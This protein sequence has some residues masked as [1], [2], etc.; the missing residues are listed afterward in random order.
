MKRISIGIALALLLAACHQHGK[1]QASLK[2]D[3]PAKKGSYAIG[4]S[5][6][7]TLKGSG[8]EVDMDAF[9]AGARTAYAG[10]KP[11]LDAKEADAARQ[12]FM[13]RQMQASEAKNKTLADANEKKAEAFLA[14]N[15][16]K[17]GVKTTASGL[18]YQVLR[19]GKGA[20]PKPTDKVTVNYRGTLVNGTEFDSSYKRQAPSTFQLNQVIPGWTEGLQLM[21]VGSKYRFWI[22]AQ[23]A[24]GAHGA[25]GV[26]GPNEVLIFDVELLKINGKS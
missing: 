18:E 25:G 19:A 20:K 6:G 14:A 3:T 9:V 26:I 4:M 17:P 8:T 21:R 16:S 1:D 13:S 15:K 12:D 2:L 7:H 23:L 11:L 24:Y 10:G 22:P 5:I